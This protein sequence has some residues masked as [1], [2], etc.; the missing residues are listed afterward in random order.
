M[1]SL[2]LHCLFVVA[3]AA[4]FS[5]GQVF[6]YHNFNHSR[7][8]LRERFEKDLKYV[9]EI[10]YFYNFFFFF[11]GGGGGGMGKGGMKKIKWEGLK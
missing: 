3:C 11:W 9:W 4:K 2:S 7:K 8:I 1:L 6:H 10:F 5:S